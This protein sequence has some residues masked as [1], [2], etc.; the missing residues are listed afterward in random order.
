M[1]THNNDCT[2]CD[3]RMTIV[4][5]KDHAAGSDCPIYPCHF[6]YPRFVGNS[7]SPA[8]SS[9]RLDAEHVNTI[10]H[11]YAESQPI[12][13]TAQVAHTYSYLDASYGIANEHQLAMGESTCAARLVAYA[14]PLG[15]AHYDITALNRLALER[16]ATARC[17]IT[18]MGADAEKF[19]FYGA[20]EPPEEG[21]G[22]YE[23]S[24]EALTIIDKNEAWVFHILPDDTGRG[25]IW[26]A[27]RVP[28]NHIAIVAN[29]FTIRQMNLSDKDN[30]LASSNVVDVA[31]R[32]GFWPANRSHEFDFSAAYAPDAN[33]KMG[34][35]DRRTWR[36]YDWAA[37]SLGLKH[38][39]DD[40]YPFSVPVDELLCVHDLM[41]MNRDHFEGTP[42]DLSI[43]PAAG[44]YNNPN[45]YDRTARPEYAS[46][47]FERAISL[48]RT[49]YSFVAVSR[50]WLPDEVGG[51]VYLCHHAPHTSLFLPIFSATQSL[52]A[53]FETGNLYHLN[54]Q[55]AWWPF[56][57]VNNF[58][59]KS[60]VHIHHDIARHQR[61][62]EYESNALVDTLSKEAVALLAHQQRDVV[63]QKVTQF[64]HER[65]Q[66][67]IDG[68]WQLF[69]SLIVKFRD[70]IELQVSIHAW[71]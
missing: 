9:A 46:G 58:A 57:S 11:T 47:F 32:R 44:P 23:E 20:N 37:P 66:V 19:G 7:R 49:S 65:N 3:I 30:F 5:A 33:D 43:G 70:G 17:A 25:A 4:Q 18:T 56:A 1:T 48:H 38:D 10:D 63:L 50:N 34:W 21:D 31:I 40:P 51:V 29:K 60:Y 36:I 53:Q 26:A 27:Q 67:L 13:H 62:L 64:T 68:W 6:T 22:L 8:Y 12:G 15:D 45:R 55:S 39:Q 42:F 2:D 24:G 71:V 16:C 54:R 28:D 52:P 41:A 59:E 61:R 14:A 35:A 69:D